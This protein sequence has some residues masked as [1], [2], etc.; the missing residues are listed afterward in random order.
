RDRQASLRAVLL[1]LVREAQLRVD[2][3]PD[4]IVD[5]EDEDSQPH[6]DLRCGEPGPALA[7]QRLGEVLDQ[8]AQLLVEGRHGVGGGAQDGVAE[9]SN[10]PDGHRRSFARG[11]LLAKFTDRGRLIFAV[12]TGYQSSRGSICTRTVP[13]AL[14]ALRTPAAACS[15]SASRAPAL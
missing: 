2:Q 8:R 12:R 14:R 5:V 6:S 13:V 4:D 1:L 15:A 7:E 9:E 3:M 10:V 11:G